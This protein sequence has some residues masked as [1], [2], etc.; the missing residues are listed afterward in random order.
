[1]GAVPVI[2]NRLV[3]LKR[4]HDDADALRESLGAAA[5]AE[6]H[7][8]L[9]LKDGFQGHGVHAFVSMVVHCRRLCMNFKRNDMHLPLR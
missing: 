9:L 7:I 3:S 1:M 8:E 5:A 4:L 2:L 6:D